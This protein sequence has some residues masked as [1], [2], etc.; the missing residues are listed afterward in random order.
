M[1]IQ[2]RTRVNDKPEVISMFAV[3]VCAVKCRDIVTGMTGCANA[4]QNA[5]FLTRMKRVFSLNKRL[6]AGR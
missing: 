5:S 2:L 1:E 6:V 4:T 3:A